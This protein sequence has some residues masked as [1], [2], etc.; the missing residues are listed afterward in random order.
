MAVICKTCN[1][2][3]YTNATR[4]EMETYVEGKGKRKR[5]KLRT[6]AQGSGCPTCKGTGQ[7]A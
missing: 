7:H 3:G 4:T 6:V 5:K 2:R 1:G